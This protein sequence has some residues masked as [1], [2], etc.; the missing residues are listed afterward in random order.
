M[1]FTLRNVLCLL[2]LTL[3]LHLGLTTAAFGQPKSLVNSTGSVEVNELAT[4]LVRTKSET[5]QQELLAHKAEL[6]N[7]SLLAALKALATPL[8]QKGDYGEATRISQLAVR[9]AEKIRDRTALGITLCDLGSIVARS[10][11]RA[12]E[13]LEPLEKSLAILEEVG[14]KKEQARALHAIGFAYSQQRKHKLALD[15][16]QKSLALSQEVGDRK[17]EALVLNGMGLSFSTTDQ[18]L[19]MTYYQKARALSAAVNDK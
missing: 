3:T 12:A 17:L 19:G 8:V 15:N 5:E 2:V 16:Y 11:N 9:I 13:A 7:P 10:Q 14:N 1:S 6:M 4:A 18:Q